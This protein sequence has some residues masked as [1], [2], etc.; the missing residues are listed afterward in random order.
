MNTIIVLAVLWN[1]AFFG[2]IP[3]DPSSTIIVSYGA[4]GC[5]CA[6]WVINTKLPVKYPEYIYLERDKATLPDADDLWSGNNMPLQLR[7]KGYFKPEKGVPARFTTA[8]YLTRGRPDPARIF[9]YTSF[10]ILKNG[11][12][13]R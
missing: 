3:K 5:T 12:Q 10:T 4:V 13:T 6:Q 9:C 7:V 2:F 8:R 1:V 11:H